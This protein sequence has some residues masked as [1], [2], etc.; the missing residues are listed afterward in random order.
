MMSSQPAH[1]TKHIPV[2]SYPFASSTFSLAQLSDGVSN[3]TALW[4][5]GQCLAMY[6]AQMHNKY[7]PPNSQGLP[8]A[9]ELGSGIGLTALA[10]SSLGWD[11]LAT[12]VSHVISSVLQKNINNNLAALPHGAGTIQVRELD[13]NVPLDA[14]P[15]GHELAAASHASPTV[16]SRSLLCPPFDLIYSADTVYSVELIEPMLRTLHGLSTLSAH[17]STPFRFPP[18]LLCIE[19]RDP[20][21]VDRVLSDAKDVWHFDVERI[22][23]KKLAKTVEQSG[24]GWN[25]LEWEGVELWKLKL[26][27]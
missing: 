8:R 5:G 17:A 1:L 3:G 13:W 9:I 23:Q 22:P 14:W 18:I 21:L 10:L 26:G 2:L 15:Y 19:R 25:R 12:D 4:L 11:V 6:L 24:V 16:E 27:I 20:M 7:K